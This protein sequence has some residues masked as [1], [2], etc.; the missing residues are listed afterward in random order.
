MMKCKC[1]GQYIASQ[2]SARLFAEDALL[3][4]CSQAE[5]IAEARG[6]GSV[7]MAHLLMALT[8]DP[9]A[10]QIFMTF[11]VDPDRLGWAAASQA[12]L[13]AFPSH[14]APKHTAPNQIF[15]DQISS[16]PIRHP[17][18]SADFLQVLHRANRATSDAGDD[19]VTLRRL[20]EVLLYRSSDL[21]GLA[22]L[23]KIDWGAVDREMYARRRTSS[24]GGW[25]S[26]APDRSPA[27]TDSGDVDEIGD[28]DPFQL[29]A[30]PSPSHA[31][32]TA[33]T[34]KT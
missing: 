18:S 8:Q 28:Y 6:A 2:T 32:S 4:C 16:D 11:R 13:N 10:R 14:A 15:P 33:P 3:R 17:A 21:A 24:N 26:T 30:V 31:W 9:V 12:T 29:R 22:F 5:A 1:C 25:F 20:I 7:E 27:S 34:R 19:T 23:R